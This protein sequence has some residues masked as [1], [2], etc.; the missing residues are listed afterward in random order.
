MAP[1]IVECVGIPALV[2][3]IDQLRRQLDAAVAAARAEG[4]S[5]HGIALEV[6][7]TAEGAR[8]RWGGGRGGG[9]V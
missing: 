1:V 7:M 2:E 8:R 9:A 3:Q 4:T 5:W 6:G